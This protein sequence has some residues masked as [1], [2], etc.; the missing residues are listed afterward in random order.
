MHMKRPALLVPLLALEALRAPWA[1]QGVESYAWLVPVASLD[2]CHNRNASFCDGLHWGFEVERQQVTET[3]ATADGP[4]GMNVEK[5][6]HMRSAPAL[7]D[8]NGDSWIDMVVGNRNDN[9][10]VAFFN[11]GKGFLI[12]GSI[13]L[14]HPEELVDTHGNGRDGCNGGAVVAP[15][16]TDYVGDTARATHCKG[17]AHVWAR[18]LEMLFYLSHCLIGA[19]HLLVTYT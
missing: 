8:L 14:P 7:G 9:A 16:L 19:V 10:I 4:W 5:V 1:A 18:I 2:T 6:V 13:N 17:L 3:G 11:D 15:A 12:E